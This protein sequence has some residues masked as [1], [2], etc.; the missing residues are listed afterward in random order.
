MSSPNVF[1]ARAVSVPVAAAFPFVPRFS[2]ARLAASLIASLSSGHHPRHR[3]HRHHHR[4]GVIWTHVCHLRRERVRDVSPR[5]FRRSIRNLGKFPDGDD[6]SRRLRRRRV[7]PRRDARERPR[8]RV[9]RLVGHVSSKALVRAETQER[10][11]E[12][13]GS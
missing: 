10:A 3:R 2:A 6:D 11:R 9:P 13:R 5:A 1:A 12:P 8:E 7:P 4:R